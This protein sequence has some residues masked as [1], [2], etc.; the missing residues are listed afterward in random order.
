[1]TKPSPTTIQ[2]LSPPGDI[3]EEA[4]EDRGMSNAELSR[5]TGLSEKH[6]SQLIN[7]KVPLS[8]EVALQLEQVLGVPAR[9]WAALDFNYRSEQRRREQN[10][11]LKDSASWMR[12][13][14]VGEMIKLGFLPDVGRAATD[15]VHALLRFFGVTSEGTW[16]NQWDSVTARFRQ[17][18]AFNPDRCALIAWLRQS[19][20]QAQEIRSAPF[21]EKKFRAA[22]SEI[23]KLTTTGP[24]EFQPALRSLCARAG[25][26]VT[27]VPAIPK[28]AISGVTRWLGS[29]RAAIHLSLRH[30][31]N[32]QLWFSFFHEACHVLEH[33]TRTIFI[34]SKQDPNEDEDEQRANEFARDFLIPPDVFAVFVA[35]GRFDQ[36]SITR[37][38]KATDIAPGIVVGRLQHEGHLLHNQC[39]KLKVRFVWSHEADDK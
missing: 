25:V 9:F 29:D 27:M 11:T 19:E 10:E 20:L 22:L 23:R 26:A 39:N 16:E 3:L 21:D 5:R 13:F 35:R 28:L 8:M 12:Q 14:P 34:D 37:F 36:T 1:M 24:R 38:A 4:L 32:D 15:R 2:D 17:S 30:R 18:P 7:A 31:T 6:I 33:R